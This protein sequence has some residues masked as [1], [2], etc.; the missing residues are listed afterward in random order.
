MQP[1]PIKPSRFTQ[2]LAEDNDQRK[3]GEM[4]VFTVY[5]QQW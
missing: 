3:G 4:N 1:V 2:K 5:H